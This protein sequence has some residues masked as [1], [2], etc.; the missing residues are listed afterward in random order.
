MR[1]RRQAAFL[2][3]H[4]WN[5]VCCTL[6][7]SCVFA[8]IQ[9]LS[10]NK[11]RH[12]YEVCKCSVPECNSKRLQRQT[13]CTETFSEVEFFVTLS[14]VT[15]SVNTCC[16]TNTKEETGFR[17]ILKINAKKYTVQQ[18]VGQNHWILKKSFGKTWWNPAYDWVCT[19]IQG[20]NYIFFL[21]VT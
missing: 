3:V 20:W 15:Y 8:I 7:F 19:S 13:K 10:I 18:N 6:H 4:V 12:K 2:I 11:V 1:I 16:A 17:S 5:D 9:T 21:I 14:F